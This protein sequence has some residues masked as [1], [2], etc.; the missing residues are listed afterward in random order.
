MQGNYVSVAGKVDGT[1]AIAARGGAGM[2][3][4]GLSQ[5]SVG[6]AGPTSR[7]RQAIAIGAAGR[8][9]VAGFD[10]AG[11]VAW[12]DLAEPGV[13]HACGPGKAPWVAVVSGLGVVVGAEV[14]A[15]PKVY[16]ENGS[17]IDLDDRTGGKVNVISNGSQAL[18]LW[19]Y[20]P[21]TTVAAL[22]ARVLRADGTVG[23][24]VTLLDPYTAWHSGVAHGTGWVVAAAVA[25][26]CRVLVVNEAGASSVV[27]TIATGQG[28]T[29]EPQFGC[30]VL[31]NGQAVVLGVRGSD[32]SLWLLREDGLVA[33]VSGPVTGPASVKDYPR[34]I[35][36]VERVDVVWSEGSVDVTPKALPINTIPWQARTGTPVPPPPPPP[37]TPPP[38][39]ITKVVITVDAGGHLVV[40]TS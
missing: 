30:G 20:D 27:G 7:S 6:L 22:C 35:V 4:S 26:G 23:P 36:G 1:L 34:M 8:Q 16:K 28:F 21:G 17:R 29:P 15:Q 24:L 2:N 14:S 10:A 12:I 37:P 33:P 38:T 40:T 13:F 32:N 5:P 9:V 25:A 3:L 31:P 11:R 39:G 19:Q 18:I